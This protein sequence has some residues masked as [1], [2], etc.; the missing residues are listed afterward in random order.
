MSQPCI[1]QYFQA[2][3]RTQIFPRPDS[4]AYRA[5]SVRSSSSSCNLTAGPLPTPPVRTKMPAG[6]GVLASRFRPLEVV[7][8]SSSMLEASLLSVAVASL[9]ARCAGAGRAAEPDGAIAACERPAS[10]FAC[11]RGCRPRAVA[12]ASIRSAGAGEAAAA[13][14]AAAAPTIGL[15]RSTR[16]GSRT[17]FESQETTMLR[18]NA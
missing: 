14:A 2:S 15:P 4:S 13:A 7:S 3:R 18:R 12:L 9:P 5:S 8:E 10:R 11:E 1:T 16:L 17:P 6:G